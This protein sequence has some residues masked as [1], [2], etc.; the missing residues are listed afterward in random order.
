[1]KWNQSLNQI[2][3]RL[4][5]ST[6]L[7]LLSYFSRKKINIISK[8]MHFNTVQSWHITVVYKYTN[9]LDKLSCSRTWCS[10]NL[11]YIVMRLFTCLPCP[12]QTTFSAPTVL[13]HWRRIF[14][15][16]S[17]RKHPVLRKN[18]ITPFCWNIQHYLDDEWV[19]VL[20]NEIQ[21]Q[22]VTQSF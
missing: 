15:E 18:S 1:M 6:L 17:S 10:Y 9:N 11:Y 5:F 21:E 8:K 4:F 22:I 3:T 16:Q 14:Q 2:K 7:T 19:D 13:P 12:G 20:G